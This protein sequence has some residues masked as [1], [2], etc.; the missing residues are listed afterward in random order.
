M[1]V[2]RRSSGAQRAA[3]LGLLLLVVLWLPGT[4]ASDIRGLR[5][6][7][8][9]SSRARAE[10]TGPGARAGSDLA[11]LRLARA[12]IPAGAPYAVLT[13]SAWRRQ[14]SAT[15][16]ESGASWTQFALA[17]RVQVARRA[18]RWVLVLGAS[19]RAAGV[20]GRVHA[21][22]SGGDWLVQTR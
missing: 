20:A 1:R 7:L 21:W 10:A 22:R 16:R 11:L 13:T 4:L 6:S 15:A 8:R 3:F 19:P 17:P 5:S 12:T 14:R 18:A 2:W 9:Q